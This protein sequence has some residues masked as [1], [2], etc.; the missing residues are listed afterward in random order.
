MALRATKPNEDAPEPYGA[1]PC[2]LPLGFCPAR[3]WHYRRSRIQG[4]GNERRFNR[5]S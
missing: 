3:S 2:G 4:R 1:K 5:C